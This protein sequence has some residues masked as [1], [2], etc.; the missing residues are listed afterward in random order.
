LN[1]VPLGRYVDHSKAGSSN[2]DERKNFARVFH[3]ETE[4][5]PA[6]SIERAR[7]EAAR[8][9]LEGDKLPLKSIV[10]KTGFGT[11]EKCDAYS[12]RK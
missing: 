10:A 6:D 3:R 5:S 11:D 12:K 1:F 4:E 2:V 7:I 9:L 8:R